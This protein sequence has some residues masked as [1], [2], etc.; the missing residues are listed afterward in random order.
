MTETQ[1]RGGTPLVSGDAPIPRRATGV[2][3]LA[4]SFA[5]EQVWF[6]DNFHDGFPAHNVPNLV[7]LRGPLDVPALGRAVDHLAARHEALRT[8][9]AAGADG[10]PAQLIDRPAPAGLE[11]TDYAG[12]GP[13]AA[14]GQLREFAIQEA[15]RP[16]RL[17]ADRLFRARLVRL[18]A[19]EHVLVIVAHRAVLD[20][21]SF[22]VLFREL[23][24]LYE[25]EASGEPA[26]LAASPVQ[27]G[28]YSSWERQRLEG[29]VLADLE[30]YWR[31]A[32]A[33]LPA[34]RFPTD[35]PRPLVASHDGAVEGIS[36]G[37]ELLDG[38]RE[39]SRRSGTPLPVTLLA[40]L[41]VLLWRY[42]GQ[43]DAV[44]GTVSANRA[45]PE[46]AQT[47][48]FLANTLPIRTDLSEDPAFSELLARVR[49]ATT[50][51]HAHQDL[52]FAKIVD[53]L[54]LE[55]DPG[56]FPVFQIGL[57]CTEP[58]DDIEPAGVTFHH[59][60]VELLAVQYDLSFIVEMRG[61]GLRLEATYPPALFDAATVRRLLGNLEVLLRGVAAD[62]S[63]RLSEL[64][65]LTA[66]ELHR[67]LVGWNDTAREF[68]V[69][70]IHEGF[71]AQV[72][73]TPDAVA[74]EF[75]DERVSYGELNRQAN[76]IA[77]RLRGVH[78]DRVAAAGG[79]AGGVEGRR[80]VCAAG[81]G[82]A[83]RAA[84]VH[85]GRY[86]D[87]GGGYRCGEHRRPA[88]RGDGGVTGCGVGA[89]P[90]FGQREPDRYRGGAVE[91]GVCDLHIGVDG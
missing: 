15:L 27:F 41:Q 83:G 90:P 65:V 79:A 44:V 81:S 22:Q 14:R 28:D 3:D 58:I 72:A 89:D 12:L 47:V 49:E 91:C 8:R 61:D 32:L 56:R 26:S 38:L 45:R 16:F 60:R 63:A 75:E 19:G 52:P 67:E 1:Q 82:A 23:A 36:I 11:L 17:A 35:R 37:H 88:G 30:D 2:V 71:E 84:G 5:Q 4:P 29:P 24:A 64:P 77:R 85:G 48:G 42:T 25:A 57:T 21:W 50:G 9:L 33:G 7:W 55:R 80:G 53:V 6:I 66:D 13:D 54:H 34:S 74:A 86:R 70:C 76:R 40:A 20:D 68:P 73:R 62:P 69:V 43:T 78:A 39:L 46:L 31:A 59:D 87:A 51:A 18:T 10:R